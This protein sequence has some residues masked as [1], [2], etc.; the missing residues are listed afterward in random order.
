MAIKIPGLEKIV[1][2]ALLE[3]SIQYER[4]VNR[5][6]ESETEFAD[7]G[8]TSQDIIDTGNLQASL[9]VDGRA[10]QQGYELSFSWEPR[11]PESGYPY[12]P[13]VWSGFFAWGRKFIPGRRWDTRAAKNMK[14][15]QVF[16]KELKER[17]VKVLS[18]TDNT[19]SL[20]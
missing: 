3:V 15:V 6:I 8:F 9:Q 5:V 14:I 19:N 17:G 13:A 16:V 2:D 1:T 11:D 4:E 7:Q 12:A 18:V 10:I 20:P